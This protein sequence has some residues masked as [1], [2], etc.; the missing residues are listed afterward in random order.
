MFVDASAL[1]LGKDSK[2]NNISEVLRECNHFP[3]QSVSQLA[4]LI[5]GNRSFRASTELIPPNTKKL[6]RP[7]MCKISYREP[8][9]RLEKNVELHDNG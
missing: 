3:E 4:N 9:L 5:G 6:L 1:I 8:S 2:T 7:R